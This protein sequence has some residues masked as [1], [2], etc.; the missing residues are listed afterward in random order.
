VRQVTLGAPWY[1]EVTLGQQYLGVNDEPCYDD[2][3]LLL[4][5]I[6]QPSPA[7]LLGNVTQNIYSTQHNDPSA[8]WAI[9][10]RTARSQLDRRS[11]QHVADAAGLNRS[12]QSR[13]RF[14]SST[15]A[16][17]RASSSRST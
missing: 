16:L 5:K 12:F 3:Y 1:A 11:P 2:L 8:A 15:S 4:P 14:S 17:R 9:L 13:R 10:V 6:A 7:C